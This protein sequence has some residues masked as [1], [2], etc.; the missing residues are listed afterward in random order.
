[1]SFYFNPFDS[2]TWPTGETDSDDIPIQNNI[3][4]T[5][6]SLPLPQISTTV[7]NVDTDN[8]T[9]GYAVDPSEESIHL[10]SF[11]NIRDVLSVL[12]EYSNG[13][14]STHL[15]QIPGLLIMPLESVTL[16]RKPNNSHINNPNIL[17][18]LPRGD[19]SSYPH[20][21]NFNDAIAC[22]HK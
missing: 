9:T 10:A 4:P 8:E 11:A 13:Q 20:L 19:A 2:D 12:T 22:L 15:K 5:N 1:M 16:L 18:Y 7:S 17:I 3:Q 21:K 6:N 14:L